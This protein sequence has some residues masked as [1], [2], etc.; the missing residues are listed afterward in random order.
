M[1]TSLSRFLSLCLSP[2]LD[3][4][5]AHLKDTESFVSSISTFEKHVDAH[6]IHFGSLDVS[7]LYGCIPFTGEQNV[8]TIVADFFER[9]KGS[10]V[11]RDLSRDDFIQLLQLVTSSNR[12]IIKDNVY[13]Q[14]NGLAMGDNLSPILAI[15]Y[16]DYI[17][18]CI[19]QSCD[20]SIFFRK[21]Y[22]DDIFLITT[23]L[24]ENKLPI[25]NN[26]NNSI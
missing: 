3:H 17:E 4:V 2:L 8:C 1:S 7:N 24:L 6:D 19:I 22:I 12:I 16:M 15:I 10:T 18:K 26:I 25:A 21:L 20:G 14:N 13:K 23:P 11:L 9:H 5:S